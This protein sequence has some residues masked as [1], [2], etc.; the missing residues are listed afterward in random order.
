MLNTE[1]T[2]TALTIPAAREMNPP[3]AIKNR[4]A[5]KVGRSRVGG[6]KFFP[7]QKTSKV[8]AGLCAGCF[9]GASAEDSQRPYRVMERLRKMMM[10]YTCTS[11]GARGRACG[12]GDMQSVYWCAP[13]KTENR[14][15][16]GLRVDVRKTLRQKSP[17]LRT[18]CGGAYFFVLDSA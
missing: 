11:T 4:N 8:Q 6:G 15:T 10:R 3:P 7:R 14:R 9:T 2:L 16:S 17:R 18:L 1:S 5:S 13:I 12:G